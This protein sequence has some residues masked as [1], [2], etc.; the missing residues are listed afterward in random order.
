MFVQKQTQRCIDELANITKVINATPTRP[1][2][3]MAPVDVTK[4]TEEKAR[5]NA[6]VVGNKR[7]IKQNKKR[8]SN[9]R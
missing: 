9:Q 2:L 3:S 6:Y 5:Y 7:D 8:V 1:L 4:E